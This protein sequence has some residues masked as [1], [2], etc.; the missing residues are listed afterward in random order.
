MIPSTLK[1]KINFNVTRKVKRS[2]ENKVIA[3][4]LDK[5][6]YDGDR[7]NGYGGYKYDGRWKKLLPK[8][9]KRYKL[10]NKSRI[11]DL[12]CKKGF[13]MQDFKELLPKAEI[14]GLEDHKYPISKASSKIKSRIIHSPYYEIPFK[15]NYFDFVIGFSAIYKY[16]LCNVIKTLKEIDRVSK[17]SFITVASYNDIKEKRLFEDWTLLG[18]TCLHKKEWIRLFKILK[19]KGDHYFTTPQS[20]NLC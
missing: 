6:Y 20:L 2:I 4:R 9:I 3:W 5:H 8:I 14:W 15:K 7:N 17:K 13:I 18:T 11:L 10:S 1:K 16:D 19:F 12:G